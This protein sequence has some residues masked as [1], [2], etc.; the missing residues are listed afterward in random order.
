MPQLATAMVLALAL[1]FVPTHATSTRNT[2]DSRTESSTRAKITSDPDGAAI[3]IDGKP[4]GKTPAVVTVPAADHSIGV[5]KEGFENWVRALNI[6]RQ[7]S[8]R[9][10][11]GGAG[12]TPHPDH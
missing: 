1:V 12:S 2:G 11:Q 8:I 9:A 7:T 5:I 4:V 6:G 3:S 10:Y